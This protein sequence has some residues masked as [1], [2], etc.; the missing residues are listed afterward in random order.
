MR[1]PTS[2]R[3][4]LAGNRDPSPRSVH[5]LRVQRLRMLSTRDLGEEVRCAIELAGLGQELDEA[6]QPAGLGNGGS[7]DAFHQLGGA[8]GVA[9]PAMRD[10]R[11][12]IV[13][14]AGLHLERLEEVDEELGIFRPSSRRPATDVRV[15]VLAEQDPQ[16]LL[17][18]SALGRSDGLALRDLAKHHGPAQLLPRREVG[19][20]QVGVD[21][22]G[23]GRMLLDDALEAAEPVVDAPPLGVVACGEAEP[24][25]LGVVPPV[26]AGNPVLDD[27]ALL[28]ARPGNEHG[29]GNLEAGRGAPLRLVPRAR[30]ARLGAKVA[31]RRRGPRCLPRVERP[32]ERVRPTALERVVVVE[33]AQRVAQLGPR[34]VQDRGPPGGDLGRRRPV[35]MVPEDRGPERGAQLR[36][37]GRRVG[38]EHLVV[39]AKLGSG[40]RGGGHP[41]DASGRSTISA[42][43]YALDMPPKP[44]P[45]QA[46]AGHLLMIGGAEDKLRQRQILSRFV[47]LAGGSDARIVIISTASSLGD[48]ATQLY[49]SLFRQMGIG[50]VRGMRP[51]VR[52]DANDPRLVSQVDDAT[53]IF[54]T[55]GNQLRLSS[56]IGGTLLGKSVI[57]RHRHGAMIA[58]TSAGAS[59]IA[60][61]MVAFGTSGATPKQRMTQM[62]AGLGLLPGVLI[63]QHFEQRNRFGRLLALVAQSPALLGIG[64]DEDTAALV[65]P[66]GI[67]EVLGKG[68]VTIIDPAHIQTDAYEVKRHRPIMVSGVTLH[69]LPS[70]YRF[71][72]RKRKLMAPLRPVSA[73]DRELASLQ[74]A[75]NQTRRLIRRIAAE[76]ADDTAPERARRRAQRASRMDREASE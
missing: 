63:D 49:V 16:L 25:A 69:S 48:E 21:D 37:R 40:G 72:I 32:F 39:V 53:A 55:G 2:A 68:S 47:A 36:G 35:G 43:R 67:L 30:H 61:H 50:D 73:T 51:L 42:V 22:L 9:G 4:P 17:G 3:Q 10:D 28:G 71:D 60:S 65:S 13:G 20:A 26:L 6:E 46:R 58:G 15:A 23:E 7:H 29:R 75:T 52:D 34:T 70:G 18:P 62:S 1:A 56:V 27:P 41:I 31:A 19:V 45:G 76:G 54:M 12:S 5:P 59:A 64:I 38:A 11:G 44:V 33:P 66:Q 57:E 24:V 74:A 8:P 14:E